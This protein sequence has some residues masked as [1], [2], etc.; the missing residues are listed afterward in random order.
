[1]SGFVFEGIIGA[2]ISLA[3]LYLLLLLYVARQ[4]YNVHYNDIDKQT[5][6]NLSFNN[7]NIYNTHLQSNTNSLMPHHT[8]YYTSLSDTNKSSLNTKKLF[9]MTLLLTCLLRLMSFTSMAIFDLSAIHYSTN[10][11]ESNPNNEFFDDSIT[12]TEQF[13][14]KAFLVLFDF[15]DFCIISAY[16]LLMVCWAESYLQVRPVIVWLVLTNHM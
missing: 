16:C 11:A 12:G 5:L 1:M 8:H 14:E 10:T 4:L 2:S 13:F 6:A 3:F 9:I 7:S 15:P